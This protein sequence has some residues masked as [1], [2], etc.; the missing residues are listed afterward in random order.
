[1]IDRLETNIR[2]EKSF[3]VEVIAIVQKNNANVIYIIIS[4]KW[5][6]NE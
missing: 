3:A 4:Y 2:D 1:M 6:R 5:G